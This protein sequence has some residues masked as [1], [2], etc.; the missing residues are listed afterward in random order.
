MEHYTD[1]SN[2]NIAF[3]NK[4]NL[5]NLIGEVVEEK[6]IS[7]SNWL[8]S[9]MVSDDN[10]NLSRKET[11]KYLGIGESTLD[12]YQKQGLIK[13]EL[14]GGRVFYSMEEIKKAQKGIK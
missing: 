3:I 12:K 2:S 4:T 14:L 1:N 7:F 13:R 11:A 9:K 10:R 8:E 5:K 6:L